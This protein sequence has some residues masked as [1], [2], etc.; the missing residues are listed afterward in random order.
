M[1]NTQ[2]V[3]LILIVIFVLSGCKSKRNVIIQAPINQISL[4][5]NGIETALNESF[6]T[7]EV[8]KKAFSLRFY[9][10]AYMDKNERFYSAKIAAFLNIDELNKVKTGMMMK[11]L[12]C[13]EPGSGIAADTTGKYESLYFNNKGHHYT[14]YENSESK[15][16]NL[17]G[18]SGGYLKLEFEIK[19][20]YYNEKEYK[21]NETKLKE[22]YLAFLIDRNLN[23]KIEPGELKKLVIKFR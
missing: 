16:L 23:G 10:K 4:F 8:D 15:R 22:F 18:K 12:P 2:F 11:D 3:H 1:K 5:Q 17:I 13:F 6:E 21:M 19:S 9:N 7:I 20:L 14:L